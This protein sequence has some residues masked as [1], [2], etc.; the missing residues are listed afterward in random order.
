MITA[1]LSRYKL[2]V[3]SAQVYSWIARDGRSRCLDI[4]W[5]RGPE[6]AERAQRLLPKL[7]RE[8]SQSLSDAID[9]AQLEERALAGARTTRPGLVRFAT[10]VTVDNKSASNYSII[11]V[12]TLDRPALLFFLSMTLQQVGLSIW[13]AKINTEGERVIDVFYVLGR[14]GQKVLDPAEMAGIRSAIGRAIERLEIQH[15]APILTAATA[16]RSAGVPQPGAT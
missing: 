8:L 10:E 12:I 7:E 6:D 14:N 1:T 9:P 11:E 15:A 4:F 3:R 5:V 16:L 13:F 2:K